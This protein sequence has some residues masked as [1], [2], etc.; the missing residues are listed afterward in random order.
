MY[1]IHIFYIYINVLL[2]LFLWRALT[3]T[4]HMYNAT[5][6][7]I[8]F[9]ILMFSPLWPHAVAVTARV[10]SST[11]TITVLS[12]LSKLLVPKHRMRC[13]AERSSAVHPPKLPL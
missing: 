13:D 5:V 12:I 2:V 6:I 4:V 1:D 10:S 9:H 7:P 11:L 8:K 3:N